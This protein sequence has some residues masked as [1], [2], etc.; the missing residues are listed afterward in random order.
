MGSFRVA[1][2][3]IWNRM[4]PWEDRLATIRAGLASLDA[5][6]VGL[7]EVVQLKGEAPFDQAQLVAA[8]LGYNVAFGRNSESAHPMGNAI[9]SRWPI[10]RTHVFALPRVDTDEYRSLLYAELD[11][12]FGALP[13]FCTHLNWKLHHGHVREVQ[14]RYVADQIL[15]FAP[16]GSG[17]PP[18]LVGDF[19]A[20]ADSDEIRFLR[21]RTSLGGTSVYFA[22]AFG[23]AGDGS[24]GYTFARTN[25]FAAPLREPNRRID[26]IF[27]RGPD[28]QRRGEPLEARVCFTEPHGGVH[29]SDHYGVTATISC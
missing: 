6:V 13:V 29:A 11:A 5:D 17:V 14:V 7:Q 21:G 4:D 15:A 2:L 19:N 1:T 24:P 20:E 26:Y 9:L 28:D 25:P 8:G 3:N 27:V 18:V 16:V 10:L 12:P 23:V 22:D